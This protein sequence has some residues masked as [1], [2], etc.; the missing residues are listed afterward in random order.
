MLAPL[1]GTDAV[2]FSTGAT[3]L[4]LLLMTLV[5]FVVGVV[6]IHRARRWRVGS[7][8]HC[9]GCDYLLYGNPSSACPECGL[10]L[11][12]ENV[13]SGDRVG[14]PRGLWAGGAL[15]V[16]SLVA[17]AVV[18]AGPLRD[19]DYYRLRP[20]GWVVGDAMSRDARV[21]N[22]AW[23]EL[24]RR[25]MPEG[26]SKGERLRLVLFALDQQAGAVGAAGAGGRTAATVVSPILPSLLA[27]LGERCAAGELTEGQEKQF[28]ETGLRARV[29]LRPAV[30]TG[31]RYSIGVVP[32]PVGLSVG[33]LWTQHFQE[34][35]TVADREVARAADG[36]YSSGLGTGR[37][38]YGATAP[39]AG[40]HP[41]RVTKTY[42]VYDGPT[43]DVPNS[44]LV[45]EVTLTLTGTL[46][47]VEQLAP[48]H[49]VALV[50]RPE[51]GAAV[52]AAVTVNHVRVDSLRTPDLGGDGVARAALSVTFN[53]MPEGVAFD[54]LLR[55]GDLEV[56]AGGP[57]VRKG[58]RTTWMLQSQ[59]FRD[60]GDPTADVVLRAN[61]RLA[62]ET[63]DVFQIWDGEVTVKGVPVTRG[64]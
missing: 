53:K 27:Y 48:E 56:S 37:R 28:I 17:T 29:A 55:F 45:R 63:V 22:R 13:V 8:P 10:A 52:R 1:E 54:A 23:A 35:V 25:G 58:E 46:H 50:E 18:V 62:R 12:P 30:R 41:V 64:R 51:L 7:A 26:V 36:G 39:A 15:V 38:T 61:P 5:P 47:V 34:A 4:A 6:L 43:G 31:D 44:R 49:D 19:Y 21:A 60:P 32:E 24:T 9:R 40:D 14:S 42:R 16:L 11:T 3:V 33:P 59:D 57:V 2:N 20:V